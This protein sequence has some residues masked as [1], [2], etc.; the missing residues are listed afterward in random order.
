MPSIHDV[1]AAS[2]KI[3]RVQEKPGGSKAEP[4]HEQCGQ[5]LPP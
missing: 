2:F 5:T 1:L 4:D 3:F